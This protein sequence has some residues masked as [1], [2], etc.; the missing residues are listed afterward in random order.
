MRVTNRCQRRSRQVA[1]AAAAVFAVAAP[2]GCQSSAA[3]GPGCPPLPSSSLDLY[4][5]SNAAGADEIRVSP[6]ASSSGVDGDTETF[7]ITACY[8]RVKWSV[9]APSYV[10]VH[11]RS[12]T[13]KTGQQVRV[14]ASYND[15][16]AN[17]NLT[18]NPGDYVL[19]ASYNYG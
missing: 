5:Y 4:P 11:P 15:P 1:A 17:T 7:T 16:G 9:S 8:G 19:G 2:S 10:T 3:G 18:I 12:G 13:L 14:Q 6:P